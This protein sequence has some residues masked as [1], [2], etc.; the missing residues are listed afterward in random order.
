MSAV[1]LGANLSVPSVGKPF[2][3]GLAERYRNGGGFLPPGQV[4]EAVA[5]RWAL[6]R[7]ALDRWALSSIE[8]ARR[9]GKA[10]PYLV[11]VPGNGRSARALK[12]D[13]A[14]LS[15]QPAS[16]VRGLA[17]LFEAE[18]VVTAGNM[19]AEADG[20]SVVLVADALTASRL[21]LVP[22]ARFISFSEVAGDPAMWPVATVEATRSA[23][24]RA[25]T[26][27]SDIDRYE[28]HESSAAAVLAW[29]SC[30][31]VDEAR[32]NPDGGSLAFGSPLGAVGA[33]MFA[34]AVSALAEG[35]AGTVALSI[36]GDGGVATACVLAQPGPA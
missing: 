17:P 18:G 23:L 35:R 11:V 22:K 30:T 27:F 31:G 1:P 25:G 16:A 3:K 28:I 8:R 13:E 33:G 34:G 6:S 24:L 29:L 20:V 26:G 15:P 14:L 36:A 21:G 19:A 9:R 12:V 32:V 2:G 4:A 7:A 10:L 5:R